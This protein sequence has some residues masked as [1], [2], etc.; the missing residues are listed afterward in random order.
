MMFLMKTYPAY[1]W[2]G[3]IRGYISLGVFQQRGDNPMVAMGR[4]RSGPIL[5]IFRKSY[6][7]KWTKRGFL[8]GKRN[9]KV[10]KDP[11]VEPDTMVWKVTE[12]KK[13]GRRRYIG[14]KLSLRW[15]C[16]TL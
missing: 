10:S 7:Q 15:L 5:K 12:T 3:V 8:S 1:R 9:R 6:S 13:A 4:E 14:V 2:R 16:D 11:Y